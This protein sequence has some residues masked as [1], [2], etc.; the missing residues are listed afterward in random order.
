MAYG[1]DNQGRRLRTPGQ[2]PLALPAVVEHPDRA[3]TDQF[4]CEAT[5]L[6]TLISPFSGPGGGAPFII[7]IIRCCR[8]RGHSG[9]HYGRPRAAILIVQVRASLPRPRGDAGREEPRQEAAYTT[10]EPIG[11]HYRNRTR[12]LPA[13]FAIA[14]RR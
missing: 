10:Q 13:M 9:D 11:R 4:R 3:S 5:A 6:N 14:P 7:G 8:M 2:R 1:Y 12:L